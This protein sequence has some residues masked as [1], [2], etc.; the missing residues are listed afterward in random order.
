MYVNNDTQVHK[1]YVQRLIAGKADKHPS[2]GNGEG[3]YKLTKDS[4]YHSR[5]RLP[6]QDQ[7]GRTSPV[8]QRA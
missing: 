5:R 8:P 4:P 3:V 6:A 7:P 1:E 2:N